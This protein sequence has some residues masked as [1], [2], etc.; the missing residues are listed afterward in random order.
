[1][2][3]AHPPAISE[4]HVA[5]RGN[6]TPDDVAAVLATLRE[7]AARRPGGYDAWR[8]ERIAALRSAPPR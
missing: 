7:L 6:A 3:D 1:M 8:A 4:Q 5:I 2:S